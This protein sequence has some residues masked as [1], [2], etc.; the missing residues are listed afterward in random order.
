MNGRPGF[1]QIHIQVRRIPTW[2]VFL[3]GTL[4]LTAGIALAFVALGVLLVIVPIALI[5]A[6]AYR[7]LAGRRTRPASPP[8]P[9]GG[10]SRGTVIEGEYT[11]ERDEPGR[12][13]R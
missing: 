7:L 12:D 10:P 13:R 8:R 6:A 9:G 2:K 3:F 5:A 11:L 1:E 4:I